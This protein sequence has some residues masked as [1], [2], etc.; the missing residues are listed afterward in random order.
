MK[1][2]QELKKPLARAL[3]RIGY[4]DITEREMLAF[5]TDPRKKSEPVSRETAQEVVKI[6]VDNGLLDDRRTLDNALEKWKR[7]G[8]GKAKIRQ[9]LIRHGFPGELIEEA[10]NEE[11]D[12]VSA[13]LSVL[14]KT[15][16]AEEKILTSEGRNKLMQLLL[17]RGHASAD[18]R[19]AMKR[20]AEKLSGDFSAEE[21]EN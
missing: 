17:R 12:Y 4:S 3:R 15:P 10:M 5:L 1:V 2:P 21:E 16:R 6:L 19:Q 13:A 8:A 9:E 11:R 18:A 14:E 20:Y 7:R